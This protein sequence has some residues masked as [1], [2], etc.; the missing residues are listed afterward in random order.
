MKILALF[1]IFDWW[2]REQ[3]LHQR[4]SSSEIRN[5]V[6]VLAVGAGL[7]IV[8]LFLR[9]LDKDFSTEKLGNDEQNA[10]TRSSWDDL[11]NPE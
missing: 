1:S 9:R 6:S 5:F 4:V 11:C 10:S 7:L 3:R 2:A 8:S